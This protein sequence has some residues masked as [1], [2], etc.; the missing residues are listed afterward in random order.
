MDLHEFMIRDESCLWGD[1]GSVIR[2]GVLCVG[3]RVGLRL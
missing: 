3:E 2:G 1:R